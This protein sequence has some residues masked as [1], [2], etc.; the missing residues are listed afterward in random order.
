M[1]W[2]KSLSRAGAR[3]TTV[4]PLGMAERGG[5]MTTK[6]GLPLDTV[7]YGW[8]HEARQGVESSAPG[9]GCG[10]ASC[11]DPLGRRV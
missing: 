9:Y 7:L 11:P 1:N 4:I 2:V 3:R 6:L 8:A 10:V 5:L